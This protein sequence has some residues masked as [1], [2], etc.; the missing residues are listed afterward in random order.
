VPPKRIKELF[1]KDASSKGSSLG[2]STNVTMKPIKGI[3][4]KIKEIKALSLL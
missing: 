3:K 4:V 2:E 1:D